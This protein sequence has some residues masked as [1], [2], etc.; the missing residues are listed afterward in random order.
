M[1][2]LLVLA[3]GAAI[4]LPTVPISASSEKPLFTE[5]QCASVATNAITGQVSY[6]RIMKRFVSGVRRDEREKLAIV[7]QLNTLRKELAD[8]AAIYSAFCKP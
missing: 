7:K 4:L 1:R 6:Q 5:E 3:V 2:F 8:F